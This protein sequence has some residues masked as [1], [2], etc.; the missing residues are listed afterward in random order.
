MKELGVC[1]VTRESK[2]EILECLASLFGESSGL[3]MDVV[4]VDNNSR[5]GTVDEIRLKFPAVNLILNND[6]FGFSRAVNQ[7]LKTLDARYYLLLNP[8]AIIL[9]RAIGKLIRFMDETPQAG[10]CVPK[11][12]NSDGTLQY[13]CRRGEARPWE[14]FSYFTGLARLFPKDLRF[15]GY[16]LNHLD[17]DAVNE[18]KAVS[19]SCMLIRR[20]VVEQIG[21]LDERY[22]AY[23]ED[24]DY[25]FH[26]R[27][28][29]WKVFY[30]PIAKV[31]HYGG[32]GGSGVSP[33]FGIY[34]WHRSYYLYY[35][36]NLARDYPFWFHPFYYLAMLAKL[37]INLMVILLSREKIVGTRKPS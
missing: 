2:D 29:G 15:T 37:V 4:V 25:C 10:I 20:E 34:Q 11:V 19:G 7:G 33:Y 8:D 22:F 9:D 31:I 27:H 24:T 23:Q 30:A 28:A 13:Q 14:V 12:L 35:R 18:V 5:D 26:A 6:N 16:L 17:N 36:K 3:D 21:Y 32:K 1:I